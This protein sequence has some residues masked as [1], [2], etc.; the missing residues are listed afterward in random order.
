VNKYIRF[1]VVPVASAGT[2]PGTE[3]FSSWQGPI[4]D[5]AAPNATLLT[6]NALTEANLTSETLTVNF[7]YFHQC[8][9]IH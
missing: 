6:T 3:A 8:T 1:G 2:S 5:A 7:R 9:N 4:T